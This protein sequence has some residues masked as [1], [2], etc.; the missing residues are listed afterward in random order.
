MTDQ[1]IVNQFLENR[2]KNETVEILKELFDS[3]KLRMITDLTEDEISVIT[4]ILGIAKLKQIPVYDDIINIY[5]ALMLSKKRKSRF[6]II[7]ALKGF[8]QQR[9]RLMG[10]FG[11]GR[12]PYNR[13]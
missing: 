4:R 5:I 1:D 8:Q 10:M 3:N 7:D 2:D 12:D 13:V 11:R 9:S 6:E